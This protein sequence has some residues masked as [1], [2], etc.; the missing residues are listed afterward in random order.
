MVVLVG[1]LNNLVDETS[2]ER[3][4]HSLNVTRRHDVN[5]MSGCD[6][7]PEIEQSLARTV[8]RRLTSQTL[9]ETRGARPYSRELS[10]VGAKDSAEKRDRRVKVSVSFVQELHCVVGDATFDPSYRYR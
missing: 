10:R 8:S 2:H 6:E 7:R 9:E 5:L 3:S 1:V 4:T